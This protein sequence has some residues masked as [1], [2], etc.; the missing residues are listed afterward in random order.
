M[1]QQAGDPGRTNVS[2]SRR[3]ENGQYSCLSAGR[4]NPFLLE[5]AIRP[6][7]SI[8][9]SHCVEPTL[10]SVVLVKTAPQLKC[11]PSLDT[12]RQ[13]QQHYVGSEY[14]RRMC[15]RVS[16]QNST[17]EFPR[18]FLSPSAQDSRYTLFLTDCQGASRRVHK[19]RSFAR[20]K[21]MLPRQEE[22]VAMSHSHVHQNPDSA[23]AW[24]AVVSILGLFILK[25]E[26]QNLSTPQKGN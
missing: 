14:S 1:R 16:S 18:L 6:S 19:P 22:E 7:C 4:R 20:H 25:N 3:Q 11:L 21:Q 10:P 13:H 17:C 9:A 5:E 2:T 26:L 23:S 15:S 24:L 12:L 8:Q